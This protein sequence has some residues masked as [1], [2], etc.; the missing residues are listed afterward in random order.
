MKEKYKLRGAVWL[1]LFVALIAGALA[2][3]I[4]PRIA[5][6]KVLLADSK[7]DN[8]RIPVVNV[9]TVK[10]ASAAEQIVLPGSV[11]AIL[12]TPI[13]ARAD[14]FVRKLYVDIGDRVRTGQL[15]AEI[16]TPELEQQ[17]RQARA[18]LA[19]TEASL[20]QTQA[21]LA[22]ARA[23]LALAK[24]TMDRWSK[25]VSAGVL[26]RQD[27]DEKQ[28]TFDARQADVEAAQA[29]IGVAESNINAQRADVQRIE[30][31]MGFAKVTAPYDGVITV[32][33]T[34]S[35]VLVTAGSGSQ[36]RELYRMAQANVLRVF[37]QVPQANSAAIQAGQPAAVTVQQIPNRV[38]QGRVA[39]TANALDSATR[40][41]RVEVQVQNPDLVLMPG[42]YTQ[43]VFK[44]TNAARSLLIPGD[45]LVIRADGT[46][47]ALVDANRHVHF[48]KV[49]VGRDFGREM[50]ITS[51]LASGQT[52]V[53]NPGDEVREGAT[54]DP[55]ATKVVQ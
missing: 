4:L 9:V 27:G 8:D 42:M 13:Y 35:G 34:T 53:I 31:L 46:Q 25:L 24:I 3:G 19:Q 39:R 43:V 1:L 17:L 11:E 21:A 30:Q 15:L 12:E 44:V 55:R 26:A 18:G 16:E 52:I 5:G 47:V 20:K 38:F 6:Q 14:G 45:A 22:Q 36:I 10:S 33:N 2:F 7:A 37:V 41:L 29:N 28:S 32:R 51:G 23:N 49:L 54:V 50:E 40:T 48:Q